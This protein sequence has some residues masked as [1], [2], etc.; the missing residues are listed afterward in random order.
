MFVLGPKRGPFWAPRGPPKVIHIQNHF[1][2]SIAHSN[3]FGLPGGPKRGP[4]WALCSSF[5]ACLV[6][7]VPKRAWGYFWGPLGAP[8]G[9]HLGGLMGPGG[10]LKLG[11]FS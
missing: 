10:R 9:A 11:Q 3:K 6:V 4:F 5:V 2:K 1:F 7:M 8:L